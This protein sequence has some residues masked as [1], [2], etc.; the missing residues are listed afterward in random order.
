MVSNICSPQMHFGMS[1]HLFFNS[2]LKIM[3]GTWYTSKRMM[4]CK[5]LFFFYL[6]KK[7]GGQA[8]AKINIQLYMF[9]HLVEFAYK[10]L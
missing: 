6:L 2:I 1:N 5:Y 10:L 8:Y 4:E 3:V 7:N 9:N